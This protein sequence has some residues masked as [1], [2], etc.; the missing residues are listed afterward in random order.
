MTW[1]IGASVDDASRREFDRF[2]R[3]CCKEVNNYKMHARLPIKG[4]IFESCYNHRDQ[5]WMG[6][7]D[8]L[9]GNF[10]IPNDAA[11]NDIIVPTVDTVRYT[12]L[13]MQFINHQLPSLFVGPTGTG[14]SAYISNAL[15]TKVDKDTFNTLTVNFSA[16]TT[17]N[18][19]QS[20][21][22]VLLDR[23]RRGVFG[24]KAGKKMVMFVDD[25]N[26]PTREVYGAQPPIELMRQFLDQGGWY[27]TKELTFRNL[28]DV[29]LV[30]AM[31][32]PGGGRNPVTERFL[33]HM[34][35]ISTTPFDEATMQD[36]FSTIIN[37]HL[38]SK[39][40]SADICG[41][42]NKIVT[43]TKEIYRLA[44]SKLLP[45]PAKSHYTFNLRDFARVIQGMLMSRAEDFV[46]VG[47]YQRLWVHEVHR[48]FG[49]RLINDEDK[50]SFLGWVSDITTTKL[51]VKFDTLMGHLDANKDGKVNTLPEIRTLFFG[52]FMTKKLPR[53]YCEIPDM[54]KL[55]TTV[56]AYLEE[57]NGLTDKPMKLVMFGF[58]IEHLSRI[59]RILKQPKGN[60]LLVGVGGSGKQSLTR[61][62]SSIVDYQVVQIELTKSYDKVSNSLF[63]HPFMVFV[64]PHYPPPL[65]A[66]LIS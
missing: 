57:Y 26:M 41:A 52:D 35:Q 48:V 20:L 65:S 50:L 42:G 11:F 60:A 33:R 56:E 32:P 36:I 6:W 38:T 18:Q 8:T 19:T 4:T 14:K 29:H 64:P 5:K 62:A 59:I 15:I 30:C 43:A 40:F 21:V 46:D 58:A 44:E 1:S 31:G 2:F 63:S 47:S 7:L 24:P 39:G 13:L 55:K 53:P 10:V 54:G 34:H 45:T 25:L 3:D 61:L 22:D 12:Y 17:A 49:D 9:D 23:R 28:V 51:G 16:T 27:D 37:W 66:T